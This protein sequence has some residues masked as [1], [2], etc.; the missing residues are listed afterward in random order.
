LSPHWVFPI[1][2]SQQGRS[3]FKKNI[4]QVCWYTPIFPALQRKTQKNCQFQI[5]TKKKKEGRKRKSVAGV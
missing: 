4:L 1:G 5:L 3:K 2:I